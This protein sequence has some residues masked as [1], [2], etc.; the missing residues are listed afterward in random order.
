M[1]T[2]EKHKEFL[3]PCIANYYEK[4]LVLTKA[5]GCTVTDEDGAEFLDFFGGILTLSLG[6][7]N[8]E[9]NQAVTDQMKT[10]GHTSTLYQSE[11]QVK[12]AEKLAQITPG[13]LKK[14]FFV[15]SGTEANETAVVLAKVFTKRHEVIVLRHSYAGR[16]TLALNT[17]GHAPWRIMESSIPGIKHAHA[18]YCYRCPFNKTFPSCDLQ[19]AKDLE[20]LIQT[21]TSGSI[22]AFMAEPIM[23][24]GGFITPPDDYFPMA[25]GIARSY[26]GVF[27]CDEVQTGF[28]RTGDKWF[29]IEHSGVEPE[30]MTMAKGIANG[31]PVGATIA[32]KEIAD[33]LMKPSISTFGGNPVS[34]AAANKTIEIMSEKNIPKI[35]GEKGRKVK[36]FLSGLYERFSHI[37][38]VRGRGLMWGLELVKDRK[39]KAPDPEFAVKLLEES[40]KLGL[41]MGK[42]G[43]YGNVIRMAPSMLIDD[44]DLDDGLK[45][46]EKALINCQKA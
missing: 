36:D 16:S 46:L 14:S 8:D 17:A 38:E 21:E 10:L 42:G 32:K 15:N 18:P 9:V 2:R 43:L 24:V 11:G 6:H 19:C 35:A 25:V 7:C 34:M 31:F 23:G 22:A 5:K 39:S 33:S 29:G 12:L 45:I 13:E 41:L 37:G 26:G 40:K 4:P 44:S 27:I 28:G 3:F 20:E 1:G 30:I